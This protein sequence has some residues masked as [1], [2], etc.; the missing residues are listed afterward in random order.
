MTDIKRTW[1]DQ[2]AKLPDRRLE[3]FGMHWRIDQGMQPTAPYSKKLSDK[4]P[5]FK[6]VSRPDWSNDIQIQPAGDV[7]G[8]H[9]AT[10]DNYLKALG[11]GMPSVTLPLY[12]RDIAGRVIYLP[13]GYENCNPSNWKQSSDFTF[14]EGVSYIDDE[15]FPQ[16]DLLE[17]VFMTSFRPLD[18]SV[19]NLQDVASD[20]APFFAAYYANPQLYPYKM[21][22]DTFFV[23]GWKIPQTQ[24]LYVKPSL[25][26]EAEQEAKKFYSQWQN[27][28]ASGYENFIEE[29][30]EQDLKEYFDKGVTLIPTFEACNGY[31]KVSAEFDL[32]EYYSGRAVVDLHKIVES[33]ISDEPEGTILEV[34]RPGIMMQHRI[35]PAQVVVSDGSNYRSP[36]GEFRPKFPNLK[37]PHQRTTSSWGSVWIPTLPQHFESPAIWGWEERTGHFVQL[38]GPIWDP[39]HYYY[40]SVDLAVN[41][42]QGEMLKNS[43][44]L[45][46]VPERMKHRFYP[47][48][49]LKR[50]DV[51]DVMQETVESTYVNTQIFQVQSDKVIATVGYHPL[52]ENLDF[53]LSPYWFPYLHPLRRQYEEAPMYMMERL[54]PVA[55]VDL[56]AAE[57]LSHVKLE[58]AVP[59][60]ADRDL[61]ADS[62]G[63]VNVDYPQLKFY[64]DMGVVSETFKNSFIFVAPIEYSD[65][66]RTQDLYKELNFYDDL[67]AVSPGLYK[68][69]LEM[70]QS[71]LKLQKE[72]VNLF[73]ADPVKYIES[74]WFVNVH[75]NETQQEDNLKQDKGGVKTPNVSIM[76]VGEL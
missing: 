10:D 3:V 20:Q 8:H 13:M 54:A 53:E 4:L 42:H 32:E 14:P 17:N 38:K 28:K 71:G 18:M 41:A 36:H 46:E 51:V 19:K 30:G 76:G 68:N 9:L 5:K 15:T 65:T 6:D 44:G 59:W 48:T 23:D 27:L 57:Y 37:Y 55:E 12:V 62:Q 73:V 47:V 45:F 43:L 60:L 11:F 74:F 16:F 24:M 61:Y 49:E 33:R 7:C 50:Y 21:R 31:N 26:R 22:L 25:E 39:L 63:D 58:K 64:Q 29:L 70:R 72:R 56:T 34:V 75:K 1:N 40:E 66:K 52:P 67:E 2:G 69:L 35:E